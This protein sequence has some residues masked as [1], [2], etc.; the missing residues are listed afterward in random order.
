MRRPSLRVRLTLWFAGSVLLILLPALAA[1]AASQWEAMRLALDHHLAEDLEVAKQLLAIRDGRVVWL[2]N[3]DVD[4]GYDAGRQRWVEVY[5]TGGAIQFLRGVPA[6]RNLESTLPPITS[7]SSLPHTIT[8]PAGAH[9]RLLASR[10]D[11]EDVAV[12]VR[13]A[14]SEDPLRADLRGLLLTFLVLGP[15][16]VVIAS[17]TGYIIAGRMLAPLVA[18]TERARTISIDHLSERLPLGG[19]GDEFDQMAGVFNDTLERLE[20]SV[21]QLQRFTADVS[22]ELRTPLTAIRSV[23][24]V[25]LLKARTSA[26]LQEVIGSMLEEADRLTHMVGTLLTLSRWESGRIAPRRDAVDLG[27]LAAQVVGQLSV[28]A[29]ERNVRLTLTT[30]DDP[31]TSVG[32]MV[33]LRQALSNV[34]DN[35]IKFTPPGR[36]VTIRGASTAD[37]V[38]LIVD[39]QGPG[40]PPAMRDQVTERFFRLDRD[41]EA[42]PDGAGLGLAIV[43]WAVTAHGGHVTIADNPEGGTRVTVALPRA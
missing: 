22:H 35:A 40:I 24:E 3:S 27:E 33:M 13:V 14:R 21:A 43:Q 41:R 23:G 6:R 25:G 38:S 4:P 19:S 2:V 9:V 32:D 39:D 16:A 28:L 1:V 15:T 26:E 7:S 36:C 11:I 34:V 30:G 42:G 18:M 8:T 31:L 17:L 5:N 12:W 20:R 10:H 37:L 29:D